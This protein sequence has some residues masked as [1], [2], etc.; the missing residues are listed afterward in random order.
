MRIFERLGSL[1]DGWRSP[2]NPTTGVCRSV[3]KL[4]QRGPGRN[5]GRQKWTWNLPSLKYGLTELLVRQ[6]WL[7]ID[8]TVFSHAYNLLYSQ[9]LH[10]ASQTVRGTLFLGGANFPLNMREINS[11]P[12][13]TASLATKPINSHELLLQRSNEYYLESCSSMVDLLSSLFARW[14]I[15]E[16]TKLASVHCTHHHIRRRIH[17]Y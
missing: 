15:A 5:P 6:A 3:M 10:V 2:P 1:C 4:V 11:E 16:M 13:V 7:A 12:T 17:R 8:D 14:Y 9:H